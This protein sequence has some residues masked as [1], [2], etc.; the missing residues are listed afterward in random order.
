MDIYGVAGIV[1]AGYAYTEFV[2]SGTL[3]HT[4]Q[5]GRKRALVIAEKVGTFYLNGKSF[6]G[7]PYGHDIVRIPVI[8]EDGINRVLVQTSGYGDHSFMFKLIPAPAPVMLISKDATLAD[9][10]A[11][12]KQKLWAGITL[13]N[14]TSQRLN[15]IKLS[16]GDGRFFKENQIIIPSLF[17]L[18]IEKVPILIEVA[19]P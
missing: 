15:N 5:G 12:E 17:P 16:I 1:D 11:G 3:N 18:C 9:I 10:I 13:L 2:N 19:E 4:V 14:T 8:L 7:D 6:Y